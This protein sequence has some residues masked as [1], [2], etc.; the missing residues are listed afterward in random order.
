MTGVQARQTQFGRRCPVDPPTHPL[1]FA[2]KRQPQLDL[3]ASRH[4]FGGGDLDH[5]AQARASARRH[6]PAKCRAGGGRIEDHRL[7]TFFDSG[8][9]QA[10]GRCHLDE[11][12]AIDRSLLTA[13]AGDAGGVLADAG[14]ADD[15]RP[16]TI[17]IGDAA[18][19]DGVDPGAGP[20]QGLQGPDPIGVPQ[21]AT[22][23]G[24]AVAAGHGIDFTRGARV[25][26][27]GIRTLGADA[28]DIQARLQQ[29]AVM[30]QRLGQPVARGDE[31]NV[32]AEAGQIR[33][34]HVQDRAAGEAPGRPPGC[35]GRDPPWRRPG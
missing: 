6:L 15:L 18:M 20:G 27:D 23:E 35:R 1:P 26:V 2:R 24:D 10:Q 25:D 5:G 34:G 32:R 8:D 13:A 17:H 7:L 11:K 30:G 19:V 3:G 14:D 31:G 33:S 28:D 4:A 29:A 12:D 22:G 16:E 9:G 21:V